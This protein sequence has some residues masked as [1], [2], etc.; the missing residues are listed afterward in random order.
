MSN[1][2]DLEADLVIALQTLNTHS[3]RETLQGSTLDIVHLQDQN[4]SNIFHEFAKTAIREKLILEFLEIL[5]S[6]FYKRYGEKAPDSISY[7]LNSQTLDEKLTPL[8]MAVKSSRLVTITQ[9]LIKEYLRMGSNAEL[10][11]AHGQNIAH[12]ACL[13]GSVTILAY[14]KCEIGVDTKQRD[15]FGMTTLHI[16]A[17]TGNESAVNSLVAWGCDINEQD[18]DGNS[19]L[20]HAAAYGSY[21]VIRALLFAGS[22]RKLKN[23]QG[24]TPY[25]LAKR[26]DYRDALKILVLSS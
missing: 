11:N 23:H 14:F 19:P 13:S 2:Q 4:K 18:N 7:L 20:H 22:N 10:R 5:V 12:L 17:R 25:S 8:H 21:R 3:F 6:Y 24:D 15:N 1:S 9:K 26:L 16:A